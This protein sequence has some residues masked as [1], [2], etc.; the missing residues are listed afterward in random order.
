MPSIVKY[1]PKDEI[2]N[3]VDESYI[4]AAASQIRIFDANI[5]VYNGEIWVT[6]GSVED[7]IANDPL[8]DLIVTKVENAANSE[9]DL[10]SEE[11]SNRGNV[12]IATATP[13]PVAT[14]TPKPSATKAPTATATPTPTPTP[15]PTQAPVATPAPTVAPTPAPEQTPIPD[16]NVGTDGD[17]VSADAWTDFVP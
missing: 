13:K 7:F 10:T 4:N 14:A 2:I 15:V 16:S 17:D 11:T 5:Q 9:E 3:T 6:I 8:G 1:E 12:S